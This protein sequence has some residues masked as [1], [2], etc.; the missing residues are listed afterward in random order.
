MIVKASTHLKCKIEKLE[1]VYHIR[2]VLGMAGT[3]DNKQRTFKDIFS[4]CAGGGGGRRLFFVLADG[5]DGLGSSS[6]SLSCIV[7]IAASKMAITRR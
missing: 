3:S 4:Y 6:S 5:P 7:A 2:F 1:R